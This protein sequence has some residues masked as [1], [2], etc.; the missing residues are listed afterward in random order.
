[1]IGHSIANK[2]V[3]DYKPKYLGE[4]ELIHYFSQDAPGISRK[5]W[6][7]KPMGQKIVP[8]GFNPKDLGK[9]IYGTETNKYYE[10]VK[11]VPASFENEHF[12]ILAIFDNGEMILPL[13]ERI[14]GNIIAKDEDRILV[15]DKEKEWGYVFDEDTDEKFIK[16]HVF[17]I[18]AKK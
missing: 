15:L 10:L 2:K 17:P 3:D 14:K 9:H 5:D 8:V 7:G 1:M 11:F 6:N 4:I 16:T 12:N 18:K 13:P